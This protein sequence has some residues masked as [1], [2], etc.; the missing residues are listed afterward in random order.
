MLRERFDIWESLVASSKNSTS[1]E[2]ALELCAKVALQM[3]AEEPGHDIESSANED[4]ILKG[5]PILFSDPI[6]ESSTIPPAPTPIVPPVEMESI[7]VQTI[8]IETPDVTKTPQK[9][10]TAHTHEDKLNG[11][12]PH[13]SSGG[14][15]LDRSGY[16]EPT[17]LQIVPTKLDLKRLAAANN[18]KSKGTNVTSTGSIIQFSAPIYYCDE[19]EGEMK[20]DVFKLGPTKAACS[21]KFETHDSTAK[22]GQRYV[23]THDTVRF[24]PGECTKTIRIPILSDDDFNTTLE[25]EVWLS[26]AQGCTLSPDIHKCRVKV[27]DDDSFPSDRYQKELQGGQIAHIPKHILMWEYILMNL[28][29]PVVRKGTKK[30]VLVDSMHNLYFIWRLN[31]MRYLIDKVL[32]PEV[33]SE[34]LPIPG[35]PLMVLM[36]IMWGIVAPVLFLHLMDYRRLTWKIGGTSRKILQQNLL[37]RFL[38]YNEASRHKVA[39][40]ALVLAMTRDTDKLVVD[41]FSKIFPFLKS[42]GL[43][44]L[45]LC[46]QIGVPYAYG[47]SPDSAAVLAVMAF[48]AL[49]LTFLFFRNAKT[50][51]LSLKEDEAEKDLVGH[52]H[53]AVVNYRLLADYNSRS[54]VVDKYEGK[55]GKCNT[56]IVLTSMTKLN[57]RYFAIWLSIII[58]G[59]Y[60]MYGGRKVLLM[61]RGETVETGGM[62]LGDFLIN[63]QI[64]EAVGRS[65]KGIYTVALQMQAT[66]PALHHIVEFMNLPIDVGLRMK[67]ARDRRHHG[68]EEL[69]KLGIGENRAETMLDAMPIKLHNV[70][71]VYP[72]LLNNSI[73]SGVAGT[74]EIGQ[75]TLTALVNSGAGGKATMLRILSGVLMPESGVFYPAHLRTLHISEEPL[76]FEG[77]LKDNLLL[78]VKKADRDQST[79]PRVIEIC[80]LLQVNERLIQ[81]IQDEEEATDKT[82]GTRWDEVLSSTNAILLNLARAFVANPEVICIHSPFHNFEKDSEHFSIIISLFRNFVDEKGIRKDPDTFFFRRPRTC[83]LTCG[84]RIAKL[85][86]FDA[87]Y[88]VDGIS[89]VKQIRPGPEPTIPLPESPDPI[90]D[91]FGEV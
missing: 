11:H 79:I 63:L 61:N 51:Q 4:F 82:G 39:A 2:E 84:H 45:I 73:A 5:T 43:L 12:H 68:K 27:M 34:S 87:V 56:S 91:T 36:A 44:G 83:I 60:I 35:K 48:P 20:I 22:A 30:A 75:G 37:R 33:D 21:A 49:M 28:R 90:D 16:F 53:Q 32:N 13:V 55:I 10:R 23:H 81:L 18:V 40:G 47:E 29:N 77:T 50:V 25:F 42:L 88:E 85:H 86:V 9:S 31:M 14:E 69:H 57:N 70:R 52:V 19:A 3:S 24:K 76:F 38:N 54:W 65:W 26:E 59:L 67:L 78:G 58:S 1:R 7:A 72:T 66:F 46:Q 17:P 74:F 64:F 89:G 15:K 41:G 71:Y 80:R 62:L 6:I 8:P